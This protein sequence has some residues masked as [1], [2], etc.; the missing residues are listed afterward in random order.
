MS[1]QQLNEIADKADMIIANYSLNGKQA[2]PFDQNNPSN[3]FQTQSE[4]TSFYH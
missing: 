1:E 3:I 4:Y 2:L